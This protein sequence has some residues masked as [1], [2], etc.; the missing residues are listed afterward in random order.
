MTI[1][2]HQSSTSSLLCYYNG[3]LIENELNKS[4]TVYPLDANYFDVFSK[5]KTSLNFKFNHVTKLV[6]VMV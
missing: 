6:N 1:I 4:P 2:F 5:K 3:K